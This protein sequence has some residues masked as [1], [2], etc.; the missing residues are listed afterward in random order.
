MDAREKFERRLEELGLL[1]E[2]YAQGALGRIGT[3]TEDNVLIFVHESAD[4]R[5]TE[6]TFAPMREM[7]KDEEFRRKA[8]FE[9]A[10][11]DD[12]TFLRRLIYW[13]ESEKSP[14]PLSPVDAYFLTNDYTWFDFEDDA[15]ENVTESAQN[16]EDDDKIQEYC[17]HCD[18]YVE[19]EDEFKV[20]KCP[21]CGKWI[22]ACQVCPFDECVDRCP[23]ERLAIILNGE[24]T[25]QR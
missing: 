2:W 3:E 9:F 16:C 6:C 14:C 21:S 11:T 19:L 10:E 15:E 17:P 8:L 22:V 20:H 12:A 1:N 4:D 24:A 13:Y 25:K 5:Y 7:Q 18:Y 23:L